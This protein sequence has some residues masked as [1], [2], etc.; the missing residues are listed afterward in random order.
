[1]FAFGAL[2]DGQQ[3]ARAGHSFVLNK[4]N[5]FNYFLTIHYLRLCA[6]STATADPK[7]EFV[8]SDFIKKALDSYT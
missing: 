6:W 3:Q 4:V 5:K 8:D 1:M 2:I 7:P